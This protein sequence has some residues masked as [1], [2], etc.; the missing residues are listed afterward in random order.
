M[1]GNPNQDFRA[2]QEAFTRYVRD[3][4]AN[5]PPPGSKPERMAWYAKL[6][7][8]NIDG[9]LEN[10]FP[11]LRASLDADAW[12][13]LTRPFFRDHPAHS[14]ILRDLPAEFLAFLQENPTLADWQRELAAYELARFDLMAEDADPAPDDLD[15][16]GDLLAGQPVVS[17]LARL[18][19]TAYPVD[20]IAA[21]LEAA[22]TP[23]IPPAGMHHLLLHRDA[24]GAPF[25]LA[26]TPGSAQLFLALAE[27]DGQ[28][29]HATIAQLAEGFGRPVD[30]LLGF[31][32]EQLAEWRAQGI[33]LGARPPE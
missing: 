4:E 8:N 9:T 29:G 27:A 21:A 18:M 12:Q 22:A 15:P 7:F 25:A 13:A 3:P 14:P 28:T 20:R 1:A 10:A 32:D 23:E 31:A 2:T 19:V 24:N 16:D 33:L 11:A 6:F 26:L 30:E 5:P 17:S